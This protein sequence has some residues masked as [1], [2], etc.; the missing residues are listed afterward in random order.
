MKIVFETEVWE[1]N[2]HLYDS[3]LSLAA[4]GLMASLMEPVEG[5][6]V[7]KSITV[8]EYVFDKCK[9]QFKELTESDYLTRVD[10]IDENG[11]SLIEVDD[12]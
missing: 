12:E 10:E 1:C 8:D 4:K 9:E 6:E 7:G 2:S 5:T 11:N 3:E